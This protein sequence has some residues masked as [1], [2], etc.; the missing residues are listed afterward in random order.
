[1]LPLE[2][3]TLCCEILIRSDIASTTKKKFNFELHTFYYELLID[4]AEEVLQEELSE[5]I[6]FEYLIQEVR[7]DYVN[8]LLD[9]YVL[10]SEV[11]KIFNANFIGESEGEVDGEEILKQ[12][13]RNDF[14]YPAMVRSVVEAYFMGD[15]YTPS[16][17]HG[18]IYC[19]GSKF[20][21]FYKIGFSTLSCKYLENNRY[22]QF[23]CPKVEAIYF[24]VIRDKDN[25]VQLEL[26]IKDR[27]WQEGFI[28]SHKCERIYKFR[29]DQYEPLM[30]FYKTVS[31]DILSFWLYSLTRFCFYRKYSN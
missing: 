11:L 26:F 18:Y 27:L 25:L 24:H 13:T 14:D 30:D 20:S 19:A 16:H 2:V 12:P 17:P 31:N 4:V 10:Q 28:I 29:R 8:D 5:V 22:S 23:L 21:N 6:L 9:K 1:M 7:K 15:T 3:D